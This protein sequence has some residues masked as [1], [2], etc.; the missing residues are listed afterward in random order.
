MQKFI[1][2]A[3]RVWVVEIDVATIKRVRAMA[4]VNLLAV[5]EGDLIERLMNDPVTLCDV[6]FAVCQPQAVQQGVSDEGFGQ[7]LAGDVI[8]DATTALLEGLV[9]FFPEP[10][11][12]LLQQAAAKYQVVQTKAMAMVQ[13][14]LESPEL[15][16]QLLNQLEK[17]LALQSSSD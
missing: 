14:R 15:E 13:A 6:L 11:R 16:T 4:D 17:E 10:K 8:S 12:R 7:G 1:D 9:A 5:V 3:G 2:R